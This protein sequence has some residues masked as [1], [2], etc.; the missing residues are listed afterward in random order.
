MRNENVTRSR[1]KQGVFFGGNEERSPD[2]DNDWRESAKGLG[3]A[4]DEGRN[5]SRGSDAADSPR[6]KREQERSRRKE[7][8]LDKETL[9]MTK[10]MTKS[11]RER[12][13]SKKLL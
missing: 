4:D 2:D 12:I 13:I 11:T 1:D 7:E 6:S 8:R 5:G 3:Y 9:K 10:T